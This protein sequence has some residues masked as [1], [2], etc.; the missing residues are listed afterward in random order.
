MSAG[1]QK[2]DVWNKNNTFLLFWWYQQW[3]TSIDGPG[4]MAWLSL[5][6]L[7]HKGDT[8]THIH[9]KESYPKQNA[10][11]DSDTL[12]FTQIPAVC[13]VQSEVLG[14]GTGL[15]RLFVPQKSPEP[16]K[17]SFTPAD[18]CFTSKENCNT[19]RKSIKDHTCLCMRLYLCLFVSVPRK[20]HYAW[21]YG[22]CVPLRYGVTSY[23]LLVN[24][25]GGWDERLGMSPSLGTVWDLS[26]YFG[27]LGI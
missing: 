25:L 2:N 17:K 1:E 27:Q 13:G 11:A 5:G 4:T 18:A 7:A 23:T 22:T 9:T 14:A 12:S 20:N 21:P 16:L 19:Q 3:E 24:P 6:A 26:P 15:C 10:C 8:H